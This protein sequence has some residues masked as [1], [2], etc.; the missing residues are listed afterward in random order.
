MTLTDHVKGRVRF[1]FYRDGNFFY[2]TQDTG[3]EFPVPM[4]DLDVGGQK[5][6]LLA[7]DKAIFFMRW[8]RLYLEGVE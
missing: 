6:T 4:S 3:L 5:F 8:I 2:K 1:T 7:E